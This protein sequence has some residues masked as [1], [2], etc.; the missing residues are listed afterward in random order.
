MTPERYAEI[1]RLCQA[2]LELNASQRAAFLTQACTG[3][4][5]LR[6]E[7]E[8]LLAADAAEN[9]FIDKPALEVAAQLFVGEQR[10]LAGQRLGNYHIVRQLGAGG[11]G[12]VYLAEDTRL[13]R[14]VALKLLPAAFTQDAERVQRFEQ[15]AQA[16]SALNHPNILTIYDFGQTQ[17]ASGGLHYI[18]SEY[19]EGQTLRQLLQTG[20]LP[21]VQVCELA[22]QLADALAAAHNAGIIHRDIKPENIMRRP[23]GYVKVLDFG[24][25]KLTERLGEG[26][27]GRGGEGE[28]SFRLVAPSP[29]LP[30]SLTEPGRV[31]GT[32]SYMSPEQALGQQVDAR[33]DLFSLGVVLYELLTGVQPF[34]G[35]SEAATYNAILNR[36]PPALTL[37]QAPPELAAIVEHALE[38]DPDLRYQTAADLRAALKRLQ[39][40]SAAHSA[41]VVVAPST[42]RWLRSVLAVAALLALSLA[43]VWY[44]RRASLPTATPTMTPVR[45]TFTQLT[46]QAGQELSPRL[47]PDGQWL[48]YASPAAGNWDL[49]LRPLAGGEAVN[50]TKDSPVDDL[51]PAFSRDGAQ[52]VFRSER[53]GGGLFVMPAR[54]GA[55]RRLTEA[56]YYP[57]WSP[58]GR[59]IVYSADNFEDYSNRTIVP[60][61]LFAVAVATGQMRVVTLGDATQPSWSPHG[62]RIA[63]WGLHKGGQRDV[64]TIPASGGAATPVTDDAAVDWNPVWSPDGKYLYFA[65]DRGGSMNLWRIAIEEATGHVLGAPE[66]VTT[67]STNSAFLSFAADGRSLVY[68]QTINRENLQKIGFDP[69]TEKTVGAPAWITQ[70]SKPATQ[71]DVSPDN[72]WLVYGGLGDQQEDLQLIRTD[73]TGAR[74]LTNDAAKDRA[75]VWSPDGRRILFL[76]DRS[77]RYEAWVINGDGTGLRQLTW[78]TG[79]NVQRPIWSADGKRV[80]CN[81]NLGGTPFIIDPDTLWQQQTPQP[82]TAKN[83][84]NQWPFLLS[85]S[86]DGQRLAARLRDLNSDTNRVAAYDF[87]TQQYAVLTDFGVWPIWLNDDRRILFFQ[88]HQA[89]V[90]DSL[91]KRQQAVFSVAPHQLHSLVAA[92]DN[93]TLYLGVAISEA[94]VWLMKL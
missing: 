91:T 44:F 36:T 27:R 23:D 62:Q 72:Q 74:Q 12:E 7:I 25:A 34:K 79:P 24:L 26:A 43:A 68:V 87:A 61:S 6:A 80:L 50:L 75:P 76:S 3:D 49:W 19:V 82:V 88:R 13:K 10:Q 31:M 2:A 33:S 28:N 89:Y 84:A 42:R 46:A 45:A 47:S 59:E 11:M 81:S 40:D 66:P 78:T 77:G 70:G 8:A 18:A 21:P 54:G 48:L 69:Q 29:P 41:A 53:A 4:D 67:P 71:P 16:A 64:W 65:S 1:T 63:Y 60:S 17:A 51:Q 90:V 93:R 92:P 52:I 57:A 22:L 37:V 58:D 35:D 32:I 39:R 85:W 30:V 9:S 94:D 55:A 73:G 56:G 14:K 20:A 15:E 5:E 86:R 83:A 38:K